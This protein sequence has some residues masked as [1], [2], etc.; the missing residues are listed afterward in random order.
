MITAFAELAVQ[1]LK[2]FNLIE[3][4]VNRPDIVSAAVKK[5]RQNY[6]DAVE[7]AQAILQDPNASKSDKAEAFDFIQRIES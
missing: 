5:M 6:D 7:K 1:S 2:A 4:N 3:E